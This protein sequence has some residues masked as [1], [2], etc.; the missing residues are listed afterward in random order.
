MMPETIERRPDARPFI[1][2]IG[3]LARILGTLV[4]L[5]LFLFY[6]I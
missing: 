5:A 4:L 2:A 3:T 6:F 1:K